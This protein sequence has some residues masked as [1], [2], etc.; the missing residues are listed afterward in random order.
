MFPP[1]YDSYRTNIALGVAV[2]CLLSVLLSLGASALLFV[3]SAFGWLLMFPVLYWWTQLD[4]GRAVREI[5]NPLEHSWSLHGYMLLLLPT[6]LLSVSI[7]HS[8]PTSLPSWAWQWWWVPVAAV[9]GVAFSRLFDRLDKAR[10]NPRSL[11]EPAKRLH[12]DVLVPLFAGLV[13][14]RVLPVLCASWTGLVWAIAGLLVSWLAFVG[15]DGLRYF[16]GLPEGA[17]DWAERLYQN[18]KLI[19]EVQHP[20]YNKHDNRLI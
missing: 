16:T 3:G 15:I 4:E 5:S 20:P 18:C 13:F 11:D 6:Y 2:F 10:Y 19:P 9:G 7:W 14:A 17:P 12:N 8:H 1:V